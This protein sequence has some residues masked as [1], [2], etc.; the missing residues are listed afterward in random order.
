MLKTVIG[1][2]TALFVAGFSPAYAQDASSQIPSQTDFKVLTD[3]RI[4]IVKAALQ[5]TPEQEKL[6][7]PVEEAIRARAETR[8]QRL[9]AVAKW[10]SQQ[11]EVDPV[12][13]LNDRSDALG[14]KAAALKKLADAWAPLYQSLNP[15]QKQ[16][17][18]L[19][20]MRVIH[21]LR[22]AEDPRPMAAYD[23]TPC[24]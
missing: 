20:A 24:D 5:L 21:Q 6:W 9:A 1:L 7:P 17:M 8:Y 11:G 2:L 3:A 14:A 16:R 15:D 18:R 13:L 23:E 10:Q 22:D 12:A 4:G 19:L